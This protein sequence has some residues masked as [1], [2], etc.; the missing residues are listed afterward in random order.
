MEPEILL[1]SRKLIV[2]AEVTNKS[3]LINF[4]FFFGLF[5]AVP[6]AYRGSQAR[7]SVGAVADGLCH[8]HSNPR[9]KLHL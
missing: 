7:G 1:E 8:S 9:S 4:F 3:A 6:L 5:R 2:V